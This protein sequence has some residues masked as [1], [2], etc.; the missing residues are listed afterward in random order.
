MDNQEMF[1]RIPGQL[2]GNYCDNDSRN[3]SIVHGRKELVSQ[4]GTIP[5]YQWDV[6]PRF[7]IFPD[8]QEV[9]ETEVTLIVKDE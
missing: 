5:K 6:K 3:I 9:C 2:K 8:M 1:L 7:F 4:M